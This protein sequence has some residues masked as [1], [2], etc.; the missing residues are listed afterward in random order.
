LTQN[1]RYPGHNLDP[2]I[3]EVLVR[4]LPISLTADEIDAERHP[5]VQPEEPIPVRAW[6]RFSEATIQAECEAVEWNDRTVRV[7]WTMKSGAVVSAVV[8]A[9]AV[10]RLRS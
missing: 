6:V 3:H 10:Q 7:R 1:R 9:S 5:M 2:S 8:W 4:P